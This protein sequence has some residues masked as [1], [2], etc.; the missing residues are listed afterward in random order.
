[1]PRSNPIL[2]VAQSWQPILTGDIGQPVTAAAVLQALTGYQ[3]ARIT[4]AQ[5]SKDG[6]NWYNEVYPNGN[7]LPYITVANVTVIGA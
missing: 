5:V 3:Y 6:V 2:V 4:G 7:S 1:M